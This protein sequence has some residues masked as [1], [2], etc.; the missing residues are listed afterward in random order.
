MKKGKK[1]ISAILIAL[2]I[3][4]ISLI[5]GGYLYVKSM[6]NKIEK[7]EV[8]KEELGIDTN[9]DKEL[10]DKYGDV[11]NIAIFGV[12]QVEGK[13]GRS[14]AIMIATINRKTKAVKLTSIMRD[15]YV[16]IPGKGM[17]KIN[18]AYAFGGPELAMRTINE[19]FGLNIKDFVAV[20]FTTMPKLIDMIGGV[21]IDID[22]EEY[23]NHLVQQG[24][25]GT[26]MQRLNGAQALA[27]SR[28]RYA[29]GGDY[30][31][32]DR[33]REVLETL[34]NEMIKKPVTSYP[35]F[36]NE[37]LPMIKTSLAANDLLTIATDVV[38]IGGSINQ[39][40]FP[41]DGDCKGETINKIYYLTFNEETTKNKLHQWIFE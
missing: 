15:S 19:N 36:L 1:I 6:L 11:Q 8:N 16:N 41:L 33:Q 39:N 2:V 22:Q 12:D 10:S 21:N 26:G 18:H 32:T 4:V 9:L 17:D 3:L 14:D 5:G 34:F 29:T 27:Y 13:T 20:N 38:K 24:V 31:R 7:V 40:R 28:I 25:T 23:K 37:V 30:K 35:G